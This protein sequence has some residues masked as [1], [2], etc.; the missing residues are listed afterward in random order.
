MK[1]HLM[2]A[3]AMLLVAA[4]AGAQEQI[5]VGATA[6]DFKLMNA[7]DGK[8]VAFKAKDNNLKV[9]VFTCNQC[10]Y[11]KAFEPRIVEIAE[12]FG[13]KGV[14]F[15]AVNPN[16]DAKYSEETLANMKARATEKGYPFPYLKDGDSSIARAYGARV[17]PH[18]FVVD[19]TGAVIYRGYVDDSAK[20]DERQTTGLTDALNATMNGRPVPNAD[21]RAFGCTIKWKS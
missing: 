17:T 5:A 21:T 19:G 4:V 10:P 11:A 9:V 1:K 8:E 6:P 3:F 20:K 13:P 14:S 12:R 7:V 16:D 2:V 18:V 15:Y